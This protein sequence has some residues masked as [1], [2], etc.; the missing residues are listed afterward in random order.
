MI[1]IVKI[2]YSLKWRGIFTEAFLSRLPVFADSCAELWDQVSGP[3]RTCT[4]TAALVEEQLL[5]ERKLAGQTPKR[6]G[7]FGSSPGNRCSESIVNLESAGAIVETLQPPAVLQGQLR[8]FN[9]KKLP[10]SDIGENEVGLGK[11][12][13]FMLDFNAAANLFEMMR[14]DIG[15]RLSA[16]A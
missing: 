6:G 11:P 7:A 1:S 5:P 10:R 9:A 15:E 14:E 16:P 3:S 2:S 4:N 8:A 13:N 12:C